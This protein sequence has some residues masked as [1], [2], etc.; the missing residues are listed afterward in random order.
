MVL[1]VCHDNNRSSGGMI[2]QD[3]RKRSG[4]WFASPRRTFSTGGCCRWIL[5]HARV[6]PFV[7]PPPPQSKLHPI[8]PSIPLCQIPDTPQTFTTPTL[9]GSTAHRFLLSGNPLLCRRASIV[10]FS[11]V[12]PLVRMAVEESY[13]HCV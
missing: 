11:L 6:P 7:V 12:A 1:V 5:P 8:L 3:S 13:Y 9:V 10:T 4:R 2:R